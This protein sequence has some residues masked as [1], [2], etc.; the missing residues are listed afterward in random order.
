[1]WQEEIKEV[2][3]GRMEGKKTHGRRVEM[4]DELLEK[5]PYA[6]KKRTTQNRHARR[7]IG[8]Q[9]PAIQQHSKQTIS[10]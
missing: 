1:M 2:L 9:G 3:E 6:D 5:I 7:N 4:I 8:C 10:L